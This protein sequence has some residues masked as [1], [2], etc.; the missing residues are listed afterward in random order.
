MGIGLGLEWRG[1][2]SDRRRVLR[3]V[4]DDADRI[5][6]L[7]A[8]LSGAAGSPES[9]LLSIPG[10]L[11][12][13]AV[14]AA[15]LGDPDRPRQPGRLARFRSRAFP[16]AAVSGRH[17]VVLTL[18]GHPPI[19]TRMV[20]IG[21][22]GLGVTTTDPGANS[23]TPGRS[24]S[25]ELRDDERGEL[26]RLRCRVCHVRP[27]AGGTFV[28][29]AVGPV[30][31]ADAVAWIEV[32]SRHLY[33][34][35]SCRRGGEQAVW[36]I[37]AAQ[38]FALSG[39]QVDDFAPLHARFLAGT[40]RLHASPMLGHVV[41]WEGEGTIA[42]VRAYDHTFMGHQVGRTA[43]RQGGPSSREVLRELYMHGFGRVQLHRNVRW[44]AGFVN[45]RVRWMRHHL[46]FA[47]GSAGLGSAVFPMRLV[48][49]SCADGP[50]GEIAPGV[51]TR[52]IGPRDRRESRLVVGEAERRGPV[53]CDSLD[54]TE[55]RLHGG[56]IADRFRDQGLG[57][58]RCVRIAEVDGEPVAALVLDLMEEGV[59][60][61][62]LFDAARLLVLDHSAPPMVVD[63]ALA[64][65]LRDA[66]AW[67]AQRG[68][69]SFQWIAEEPFLRPFDRLPFLSCF[70][71]TDC[72]EGDY[73]VISFEH[74]PDFLEY[75]R[76][77]T[78]RRPALPAP[79][80]E[81]H[82]PR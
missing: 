24:L 50:T 47:A 53:W 26:L 35:T 15:G 80:P 77:V 25:F 70:E 38:Y 51:W 14:E 37:L 1:A 32:A 11:S 12:L 68:R 64:E 27:D 40:G 31:T 52:S 13:F 10:G 16:R 2:G 79:P 67:Y 78:E 23:L 48:E 43:P 28:G 46:D 30:G 9:R 81:T 33:P 65:L 7:W 29:L 22:Q 59:N 73:W 69:R 34:H 36:D 8:G 5:A 44:V 72:G 6:R 74:I 21:G 19:H 55:G 62:G 20:E 56:Q 39:K 17:P 71:V 61:F 66:Q 57:R 18:P 75:I 54:M 3:E 76:E 49:V 45:R 41:R 58:D 63:A 60:A 42:F 4:I 82:A